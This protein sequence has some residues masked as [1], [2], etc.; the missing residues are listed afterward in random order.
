MLNTWQRNIQ[1]ISSTA[2][3]QICVFV[4]KITIFME[5]SAQKCAHDLQF[6][7]FSFASDLLRFSYVILRDIFYAQ[8]KLFLQFNFYPPFSRAPKKKF[9][10]ALK[11]NLT[12]FKIEKKKKASSGQRKYLYSRVIYPMSSKFGAKLTKKKK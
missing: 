6:F 5:C 2:V 10:K 11:K 8:P 12:I 9:L 7:S 3:L 4:A 1:T